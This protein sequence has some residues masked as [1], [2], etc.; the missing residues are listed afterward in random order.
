MY[1]S[2]FN[3]QTARMLMILLFIPLYSD[4]GRYSY[5][6]VCM[7]AHKH[8]YV[9]VGLGEWS[10]SWDGISANKELLVEGQTREWKSW[11]KIQHSKNEDHGIQS[12]YFMANRCGKKWKQWQ[13]LFSKITVDRDWRHE[14]KSRLLLGRKAMTNLNS[15]LKIRD[16][17]L[18]TEVC[19]VKAMFFPVVMCRCES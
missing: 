6:F 12:H 13:M 1:F 3:C 8:T 5:I 7:C 10:Y 9:S 11:L 2:I 15:I 16:H 19:I 4:N 17:T 14:I 18:P